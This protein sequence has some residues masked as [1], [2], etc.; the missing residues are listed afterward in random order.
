MD[1]LI[2][3]IGNYYTKKITGSGVNPQGVDWKDEVG[4]L[5]RFDQLLNIVDSEEFSIADL[6]CGYGKLFEYMGRKYSKFTYSGYDLSKE[7]I[8]EASKLYSFS[9]NGTF[10]HINAV[11]EMQTADYILASGIFNVKMEHKEAEWLSYI[12]TT[13]EEMNKK[14]LKGF[15]FNILT[16]YSDKEY[17][18]DNLYYADPSFFFD[19]CK[20]NFS[21]NVSL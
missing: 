6:G 21:L 4:Q 19:Y 18:K 3:N 16:K 9:N 8:V 10:V 7:M 20:R 14:S 1:E 15:S 5:L 17:M 11:Q 12:L 2:K 13:I